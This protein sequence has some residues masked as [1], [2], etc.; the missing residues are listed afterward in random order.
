MAAACTGDL[1]GSLGD[2]EC[3][4]GGLVGLVRWF[5]SI[6]CDGF[7]GIEG[8]LS[9]PLDASVLAGWAKPWLNAGG[10]LMFRLGAGTGLC[11]GKCESKFWKS[12]TFSWFWCCKN[13]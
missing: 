1:A 2:A 9:S 5:W 8:G 11:L 13:D 7:G 3:W 4:T 6:S 10:C 12:M